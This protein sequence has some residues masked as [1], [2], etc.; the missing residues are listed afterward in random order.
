MAERQESRARK[1]LFAEVWQWKLYFY[2]RRDDEVACKRPIR[3]LSA[4]PSNHRGFKSLW[5]SHKY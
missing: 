4:A 5:Q 1:T 2:F 3:T